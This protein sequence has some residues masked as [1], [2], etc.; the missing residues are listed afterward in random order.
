MY[1]PLR[2][3][4]HESA[5]SEYFSTV[6]K[7]MQA[8]NEKLDS[9]KRAEDTGVKNTQRFF[10]YSSSDEYAN[11]PTARSESKPSAR[12]E[13]KPSEQPV[14]KKISPKLV[15]QGSP[16]KATGFFSID[17]QESIRKTTT[18]SMNPVMMTSRAEIAQRE[19]VLQKIE[20]MRPKPREE[21]AC[22]I[23]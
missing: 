11:M 2:Y 23:S 22:T 6:K 12:S 4:G 8:L 21:S 15:P 17:Q 10:S 7:Q 1:K 14:K 18:T 3:E 5:F 16:A 20:A 9:P 19:A 13:S